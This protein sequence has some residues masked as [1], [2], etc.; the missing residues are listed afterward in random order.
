MQFAYEGFTHRGDNRCFRFRGMAGRDSV[1][2]Y[3]IEVKL[4]LFAQYAV[5]VQDGPLL[6]LQMLE[7][8]SAAQ[9]CDLQRYHHYSAVS[10]DF[11]PLVVE[12]EKKQA[13]KALKSA[14]R[15]PF[16]KPAPSS[17]VFLGVPSVER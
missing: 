9:P 12:R 14:A 6:C 5:P 13:E 3:S 16:R 10:E 2:V 11:R 17:N 4:A 7:V 1:D 15:K 8:A